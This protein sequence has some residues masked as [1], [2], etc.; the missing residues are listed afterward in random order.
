MFIFLLIIVV[1]SGTESI[2]NKEERNREVIHI[3]VEQK[4]HKRMYNRYNIQLKGGDVS[5]AVKHSVEEQVSQEIHTETKVQE[6]VGNHNK[7]RKEK[8]IDR[9]GVTSPES[10][11]SNEKSK[12]GTGSIKSGQQTSTN[13]LPHTT[14]PNT[15]TNTNEDGQAERKGPISTSTTTTKDTTNLS[16]GADTTLSSGIDGKEQGTTDTTQGTESGAGKQE[17][18]G[19]TTETEK[20]QDKNGKG[21]SGTEQS[22]KVEDSKDQKGQ[23]TPQNG[24]TGDGGH[25]EEDGS[26]KVPDKNQK[27]GIEGSSEGKGSEE[28]KDNKDGTIP[29]TDGKVGQAED[30]KITQPDGQSGKTPEGKETHTNEGQGGKN[31]NKTEIQD[32]TKNKSKIPKI[33]EDNMDNNID[34]ITNSESENKTDDESNNQNMSIDNA[35]NIFIILSTV[36]GILLF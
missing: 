30:G 4:Q 1:T 9:T 33:P 27:S 35:S 31:T 18:D 7:E 3:Q 25:G 11:S 12:E 20:Q 13:E 34:R 26:T 14:A 16:N 24:G 36:I 21:T 5:E 6:E 2:N 23:K 22:V 10:Q 29:T 28:N 17:H 32:N 15:Q 8:E 19:V